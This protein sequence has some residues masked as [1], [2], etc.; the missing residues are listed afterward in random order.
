MGNKQDKQQ[1]Q[2]AIKPPTLLLALVPVFTMIV[3]LSL[4]YV[5][6]ELPPEPLII[7]S[8]I[9]AGIVAIKLGHSYDAILGSISEKIAKTMPAILILI[10]VGFMIGTWMVGGTIPM[11]IYYG[12]KIID[13]QFL[14]ITAFLVTSIVSICTGTSWGA[15]GTIGVAFMGVA[16]GMDANLGAVAG[17]VVAGAYF[18]DKL[19]PL[20]DTTNIASLATGVNL[21][22]H[23]GHLLYTT[24]PS[25][26]VAG[27]VY[28]ITG[29]NMGSAGVE[30]PEKVGTIMSTLNSIFSWNLLL[31]LPILIILFG[32]L[33][34]KPTIPVMLISSIVAMI[35]GMIFQGFSIQDVMVSAVG[36]FNLSMV[37]V[38]GFDLA[39]VIPDIPRLLNRGGMNSMMSTLLICFSAIVFAGTISVTKSLDLIIN[40][41]MRLVHSTGSLIVTTILVGM[42]MIGITSNGQISILMPGEMLRE[43]YIR[44]GL[45]PKNLS[46]TIEDSASIIEPILPWTAAGAYMA[47][48]LGVA[49]LDYLPWAV[50][51]WTGIIFATIWGFTGFGIAKLTPEQQQE[52]LKEYDSEQKVSNK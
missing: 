11:M 12:L 39:T 21:Y 36:G 22:E 41:L 52:M 43:S 3:L 28:A 50:F 19:S 27:I 5:L 51:C 32:S 4:G 48:T 6:F 9:V 46:R 29:L 38:A 47:G 8:A 20:S 15:A 1:Q 25:F 7:M 44:R 10:T 33:T 14:I 18:G 16:A 42:S 26:I 24:L 35:N 31:L 49:T 34:K 13:P 45:H 17:A 23:I 2:K 40:K 30:I 37:N